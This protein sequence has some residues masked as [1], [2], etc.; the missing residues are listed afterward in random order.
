M[1]RLTQVEI[2]A[3]YARRLKGVM[4]LN[5]GPK[6]AMAKILKGDEDL[7]QMFLIILKYKDKEIKKLLDQQ[8]QKSLF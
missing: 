7:V 1:A 6:G 4:V 8:K 2:D 5:Y 3:S